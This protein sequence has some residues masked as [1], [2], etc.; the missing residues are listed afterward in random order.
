MP[1]SQ[2]PSGWI[3]AARLRKENLFSNQQRHRTKI[4]PSA[5]D[6]P[7]DSAVS[8]TC[9]TNQ[10]AFRCSGGQENNILMIAGATPDEVVKRLSVQLWQR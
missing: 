8:R 2:C 7:A 3:N 5:V 6:N 10:S 9:A 1:L 4:S